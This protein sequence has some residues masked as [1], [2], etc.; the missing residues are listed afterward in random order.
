MRT[1]FVPRKAMGISV[2]SLYLD[3]IFLMKEIKVFRPD[4]AWGKYS[5]DNI[6]LKTLTLGWTPLVLC[7]DMT[8]RSESNQDGYERELE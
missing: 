1:H 7:R 2:G 4:G 6:L 3:I 5:E 8:E